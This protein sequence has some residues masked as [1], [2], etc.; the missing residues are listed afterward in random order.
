MFK[1][2]F[3]FDFYS[4]INSGLKALWKSF[5]GCLFHLFSATTRF[6]KIESFT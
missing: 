4:K 2:V 3:S 5:F 6:F 1:T